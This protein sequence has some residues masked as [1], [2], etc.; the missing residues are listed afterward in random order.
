MRNKSTNQKTLTQESVQT[1]TIEVMSSKISKYCD[2][3]SKFDAN[4][5]VDLHHLFSLVNDKLCDISEIAD[6]H[7][8]YNEMI[9]ID[10]HV[11]IIWTLLGI[12]KERI[13]QAL[14]DDLE[15]LNSELT[16]SKY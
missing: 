13:P 1:T 7:A 2:N 4:H 3:L 8:V 6:N 14:F 9:A 11:S 5:G 15:L 16:S 10:K 12:I